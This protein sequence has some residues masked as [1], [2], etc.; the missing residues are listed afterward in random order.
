MIIPELDFKTWQIYDFYV[1]S[2]VEYITSK[3]SYANRIL[4]GIC[5]LERLNE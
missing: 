3:Q 4:F 2:I 1:A 5:I